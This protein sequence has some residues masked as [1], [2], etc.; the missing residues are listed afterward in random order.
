MIEKTR[1]TLM[2]K[3]GV[4]PAETR[5]GSIRETIGSVDF[6]AFSRDVKKAYS[7]IR[8]E[9]VLTPLEPSLS[10]SRMLGAEI[11]VKW[12]CLQTTGSFKLR[13]AMNKIL[14]L[15]ASQRRRG[16]VSASTGNHGLAIHHAAKRHGVPLT[17][18]LPEHAAPEKIARL[19]AAGADLAFFGASC[20]LAEIHA[21]KHALSSGRVFVSPY[22]DLDI[23]LGQ[24]TVGLEVFEDFPGVEDIVVPIGGG[25]LIAGVGGY[26]KGRNPTIRV[27]GVEPVNSAFMKASFE[28]GRLIDVKEKK[29]IADA[30]AGGIEPGSVTF[31]LCRR[32]VD[33]ICTVSEDDIKKSMALLHSL[34]GHSVEGAGALSL[35]AV[36]TDP[37]TFRGRRVVLVVSGMNVAPA[38]FRKAMGS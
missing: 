19:K 15:S 26:L 1:K 21:R 35:A 10:L 7:A 20:D 37:D 8:K 32:Y 13:G 16:V 24:G 6:P 23:I 18:F 34:H 29:T 2:K 11:Y 25:G 30:V 27:V 22:N 5:R 28:A 12:E 4:F 33:M 17:L 38:L 9:I 14:G 31:P 36:M 3:S